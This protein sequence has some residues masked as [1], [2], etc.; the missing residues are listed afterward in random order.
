MAAEFAVMTVI[1]GGEDE[2]I[3]TR[4]IY[5]FNRGHVEREREKARAREK[6]K[7]EKR[8]R[9]RESKRAKEREKGRERVTQQVAV[10]TG[11]PG[12]ETR[13]GRCGGVPRHFHGETAGI[14]IPRRLRTIPAP[15]PCHPL[16]ATKL[17]SG[18]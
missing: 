10:F 16:T 8:Q 18:I 2:C 13:P 4:G 7:A 6:D 17:L 5:S 15:Y 1:E 12:D 9:E 3:N 14:T 11:F